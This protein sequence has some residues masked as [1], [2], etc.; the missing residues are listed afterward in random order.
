MMFIDQMV[1]V[2]IAL[3]NM[4]P[5]CGVYNKMIKSHSELQIEIQVV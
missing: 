2:I 4:S 5:Q 3:R 1:V